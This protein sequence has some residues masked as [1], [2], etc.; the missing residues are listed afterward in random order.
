[1]PYFSMPCARRAGG[2]RA[3]FYPFRH[4]TPYAYALLQCFVSC[5]SGN[6][7]V[8]VEAKR[9]AK[10]LREASEQPLLQGEFLGSGGR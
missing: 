10:D 4:P 7:T 3:V 8:A 2:L 5:V 9:E 1:M 6:E